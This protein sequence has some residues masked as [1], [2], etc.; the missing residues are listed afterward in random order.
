MTTSKKVVTKDT[1]QAGELVADPAK[2]A[3]TA[4]IEGKLPDINAM[5]PTQIAAVIE[6]AAEIKK[7]LT[8]VEEHGMQMA[9][10]GE[11]VPGMKLVKGRSSRDFDGEEKVVVKQL[12]EILKDK[13]SDVDE[14]LFTDPKLKTVAALEKEMGKDLFKEIASLV[15]TSDGKPT[16]VD[17]SDKR[18]ALEIKSLAQRF[19]EDDEEV[20][21]EY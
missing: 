16:L 21:E 13:V 20:D 9:L 8:A 3:V 12:R 17:M 18:P 7:W 10:K 11:T 5:T 14:L 2:G 19:A 4:K 6:K 1:V 15:K